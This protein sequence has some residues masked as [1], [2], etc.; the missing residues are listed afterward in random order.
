MKKTVLFICTHNSARSIMAEAILRHLYPKHYEVYSCG[1]QPSGI[2]EN[3]KKVLSEIGIDTSQ[4]YSKHLDEFKN[5]KFDYV[6]T[7]CD[8]AKENCPFFPGGKQYI[9]KGFKDPETLEDFREVRDE[10]YAWIEEFF[11][12]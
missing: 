5:K 2:K 1:T 12:V 7:V 11:K 10:I 8:S 9:H 6:I 4:L 3:T